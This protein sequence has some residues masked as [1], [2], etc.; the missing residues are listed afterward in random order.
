M[1][2]PP[3]SHRASTALPRKGNS[4]SQRLLGAEVLIW[5]SWGQSPLPLT[6]PCTRPLSRSYR[7]CVQ[8]R[9]QGLQE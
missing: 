3:W 9:I 4:K 5:Q 7:L 2:Q 1:P 6:C 8:K